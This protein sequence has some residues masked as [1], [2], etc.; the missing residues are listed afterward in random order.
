MLY[1]PL[2]S[3]SLRSITIPYR[4]VNYMRGK[5][6]SRE[7]IFVGAGFKPAPYHYGLSLAGTK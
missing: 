6:L 1:S 4:D 2:L 7:A 5:T 3:L